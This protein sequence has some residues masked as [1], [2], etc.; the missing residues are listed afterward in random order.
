MLTSRLV[1]YS[2]NNISCK[3]GSN[4]HTD[5]KLNTSSDNYLLKNEA[6]DSL[7]SEIIEKF[8]LDEYLNSPPVNALLSGIDIEV[9]KIVKK[10]EDHKQI[11]LDKES[12][13][14][15][16]MNDNRFKYVINWF[17]DAMVKNN[18]N[19]TQ[20]TIEKLN[21]FIS[22]IFSSFMAVLVLSKII[23]DDNSNKDITI[24]N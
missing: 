3:K 16:I 19:A 2:E 21:V 24:K 1:N 6:S 4:L 9:E 5:K 22:K 15:L 7:K 23:S 20:Q 13:Y 17:I 11:N 8:A 12:T 14:S 10:F 18:P